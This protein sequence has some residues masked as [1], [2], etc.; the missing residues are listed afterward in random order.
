MNKNLH[1]N[2]YCFFS[3][4]FL[5]V[6]CS[7][8][9][10][11]KSSDSHDK[12]FETYKANFIL[13]L[14]EINPDWATNIGYHEFDDVLLVPNETQLR[15][16]LSFALRH[17]DSLKLYNLDQLSD[18]NK[19]DF[20]LIKNQLELTQFYNQSL[21]SYEWDPTYYNI[22]G[23][24]AYILGE[25]YAPLEK[26]ITNFF[27]K[28]ERIP[29]YYAAAKKNIINPSPLHTQLAIEQMEAGLP[30][31]EKDL[32]D[33]LKNVQ[34]PDDLK[35]EILKRS[36][37][38]VDSIKGFIQ[39]LKKQDKSKGRDFRLGKELY[40]KKFAY[41]IQSQ[42]TPDQ[43]YDSAVARKAFLH[44]EMEKIATQ[45]WPKYM[46]GVEQPTDKL[47]LIKRLIDTLSL[48]HTKADSFKISIQ[49]QLPQLTEFINRKN[50]LYL[51]P[52]KPLEVRDEP[53]YM[54]GVAGASMSSPG[55]YET[56]GKAYYNVG[57]LEGWSKEDA[58][59]YLRE[60]NNY[61]LQILNIHEA[62]PGHYVQLVYSNK[63]PSLI[64]SILQNNTMI[65]G[66][67]VYSELMMMENG[68][69]NPD[70]NASTTTP[71]FWLM[72]Y[73]W[74]LRST[75]NTILDIG[76]H[77][78]E[79]SKEEAMDLLTRQAFQQ[80]SEAEGKWHRVQ[81]TNVQLTSYYTGFKEIMDLR[82][83]WQQKQGKNYTLKAFNEKFL[84]Y[85]S[86]PV[87]YIKELMLK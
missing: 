75:C 44:Q 17:L 57:T 22:G 34:L 54:A 41:E 78:R 21:K 28:M 61:I 29:A 20:Y 83:L 51:D 19:T 43:I 4:F 58:E 14:W 46:K 9:N 87:K 49:Q 10:T 11:E 67:A 81:V 63:S 64:K 53:G 15:T 8:K 65:E 40:A 39:F 86:A 25:N 68:Y 47:V 30:I 12:L 45:L 84:S 56:N 18:N 32:K 69:G 13:E 60:Y 42:Y 73:K 38:S 71:E 1:L 76:V 79:M 48:Q 3:V 37:I 31:F 72:Y 50:L 16:E 24:F 52:K 7:N 26:R 70:P 6:S 2:I 85:G 82:T 59:S 36:K 74:N 27:K 5:L 35:N 33:S 62:L 55:P 77:T 66:W 23:T 80:K